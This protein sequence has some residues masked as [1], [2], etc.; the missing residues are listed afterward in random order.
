MP[1]EAKRF[2]RTAGSGPHMVR[3]GE[4][5]GKGARAYLWWR[6]RT[7]HGTNWAKKSLGFDLRDDAGKIIQARADDAFAE[8]Q[9][10][11]E[12]LSG[13][14]AEAQA[15]PKVI[16]LRDTWPILTNKQRGKYPTDTL[17]RRSLNDALT[18]ARRVLGDDF[19]WNHFDHSAMQQVV[20]EKVNDVLAL[21]ETTGYR[22]A[23]LYGA[24]LLTIGLVLRDRD[25]VIDRNTPLPLGKAWRQELAEYVSAQ[26]NHRI[27][28]P[29]R[30]RHTIDEVRTLLAA[31]RNADPRLNLAMQL[32]AEYREGQVV[33][34]LRSD[35]NL[36]DGT[37]QIVSR[38]KKMGE[39]VV[40]TAGQLESARAALAG[41]LSDLEAAYQSGALSD[42]QL[43]PQHR[44]RR[45]KVVRHVLGKYVHKRT[46]NGWF[47]D[48]EDRCE[49]AHVE[50]RSFY[51]LRRQLLDAAKEEGISDE[52]LQ[53]HGGWLDPSTPNTVYRDKRQLKARREARDVRSRIR[54]E[55]VHNAYPNDGA[56]P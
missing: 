20:R 56:K 48:L 30:P 40:L 18:F 32:G 45:G 31:A 36:E 41:Y 55:T 42:Y 7:E 23:E 22:A 1:R 28:E 46:M 33:R 44:L 43:F 2:R 15:T 4:W 14:R 49:I 6:R 53:H 52:A 37:F 25:R 5:N 16:R 9:R 13:K 39:L 8:A 51:G 24:A 17:Y 21:G 38:G 19:L 34:A 29:Q 47:R 26:N 11:Y 12:R 27:P 54:G 50:G 35:L 3:Y 10:Q